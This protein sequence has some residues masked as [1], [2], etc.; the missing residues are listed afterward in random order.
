MGYLL[1]VATCLVACGRV[2][3]D[4][5]GAGGDPGWLDGYT[6]RK[7][8]SIAPLAPADLFDLPVHLGLANDSDLAQ[9]ARDDGADLA[10]TADDGVSLLARE[11]VAYD[12][13]SG[14]RPV[15][16]DRGAARIDDDCLSLLWRRRRDRGGH[17]AADHARRVA[18][19]RGWR[20]AP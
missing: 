1:V 18:H 14:A 10:I 12:G 20:R 8:I 7:Q 16:A 15:D 5:V 3:F 11:V 19:E 6:Y 4:P 13:A 17:L 9:H 2:G